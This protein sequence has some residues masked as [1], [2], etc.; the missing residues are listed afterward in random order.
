VS[1]L[2][3]AGAPR[4][5]RVIEDLST[6]LHKACAGNKDG[7]LSAVKQ[8]LDVRADVHAL[9]K[10]RET[11]LLTA[12][13]HGQAAAV[14]ALLHAGADPCRCTD[15]G[16]SPLSIAAY[17]GHDDVV[18]LLLEQGAPTEEEDP[19]LSALLQAATKGLPHTVE[20]LL[21]HGA[22]H[23]VTTKK[24]DTALSIL[25][26]QNHLDAAVEMVTEYKASVPRCS[27]D[28]KKV[29]RARL[30]INLQIKK[31]QKEEG[32]YWNDD[33]DQDDSDEGSN[34]ALH[35]LDDSND[36]FALMSSNKKQKK[37]KESANAE[38][39]AKAAADALLLEL[40]QEDAKALQ[41]E[42][43]AVS[44]RNKKKKKKERERHLKQEQEKVRKE[45]E[46]KEAGERA[47]TR[48][49]KEGKDRK[50]REAKAKKQKE[51]EMK[52]AADRQKKTTARQNEKKRIEHETR[53][54]ET[55]EKERLE[56]EKRQQ[57]N[58]EKKR[59]E[60]EKKAKK[61][62][63]K[64]I[65]KQEAASALM[66]Q[67]GS[68]RGWEIGNEQSSEASR[69]S[70]ISVQN[71]TNADNTM[72]AT[73]EDELE[74]M[75]NGVVGFLGFDDLASSRVSN[76]APMSTGTA[77]TFEAAS[78]SASDQLSAEPAPVA[79]LRYKKVIELLR[80]ANSANRPLASINAHVVQTIIY[81]WIV[82]ASY[83]SSPFLDPLIPSWTD[84]YMLVAFIQRQLISESRKA[85]NGVAS[86]I[87]L[88]KE[89]GSF[90]AELCLSLASDVAEFRKSFNASMGNS[91]DSA[92]NM[93]ASEF[94]ASNGDR[95]IGIDS[96]DHSKVNLSVESFQML[97]HRFVGPATSF[98]TS[99]F[100]LKMR[101][102]TFKMILSGSDLDCQL[103]TTALAALRREL[104]VTLEL[105][106]DPFSVFRNNNF[107]G[108]FPDV[109]C[110]FGGC[111]PFAE[112]N[113]ALEEILC[114][115]GGSVAVLPS[116]DSTTASFL[117]KRILDILESTE[118]KGI[119]LSFAL[120]LPMQAFRD[121]TVSP[122]APD[123]KSLDSRLLLSH[124]RFICRFETLHPGQHIFQKDAN[125]Q[126]VS[127]KNG[128]IM[129]ILQNDSGRNHFPVSDQAESNIVRSLSAS[130]SNDGFQNGVVDNAPPAIS[131]PTIAPH[132]NLTDL[133]SSDIMT[134][135]NN[136]SRRSRFFDL[137]DD[138]E[139]SEH[140]FANLDAY[141]KGML[142]DLDIGIVN[143]V[144]VDKMFD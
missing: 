136:G 67:N 1:L 83:D 23:T 120:F 33:S 39:K 103:P 119:P 5:C 125:G 123:L 22:D 112:K 113:H 93:I 62:T 69:S 128:S 94:V 101:Y 19:T 45:K 75:A 36:K 29:Q 46:E 131:A 10:W 74:N 118:G 32:A 139:D 142:N 52:E 31:Q 28:R 86:N 80:S 9:N 26:E 13:N 87:E 105:W 129:L 90:L 34:S 57:E 99:V 42:A 66:P 89:A 82:R 70:N 140:D 4:N 71:S 95:M 24:G 108:I 58:E 40:E 43:S 51:Q 81:K 30:L 44:K 121:L 107:C 53:Q 12:A 6:P 88:L 144:N 54:Q 25:V 137:V 11:P 134:T 41:D 92:I 124:K 91:S 73:V 98:L 102:D 55:R 104:K 18:E 77:K 7:H 3:K 106:T 97:R 16:W 115:E 47:E 127:S 76:D 2:L 27:R 20:L 135:R 37:G 60:Q 63:A 130:S 114:K 141:L 17:K 109:D 72:K 138:G 49:I 78:H 111:R 84:K 61:R 35:D 96:N 79:L 117:T 21:R 8:L 38:N 126:A 132:Q 143:D 100:A 85:S 14:E 122:N 133:G 110:L 116:L 68:K 65:A 64:K 59:L 56:Q 15:T 48:R 50:V